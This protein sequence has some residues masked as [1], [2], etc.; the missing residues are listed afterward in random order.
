MLYQEQN[1]RDNLTTNAHRFAH[2]VGKLVR[3]GPN[4]LSKD[5]VCIAA[6][7]A[8]GLG[9]L[10]QIVVTRNRVGLS[11]V[12]GFDGRQGFTVILNQLSKLVHQLTAVASWKVP[13][14]GVVERGA[15]SLDGLV[16]VLF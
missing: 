2:S 13:P 4:D 12:A 8:E 7:V 10:G 15:R 14:A 5:L 9:G 16:D 11:I 1:L 6:V 3:S